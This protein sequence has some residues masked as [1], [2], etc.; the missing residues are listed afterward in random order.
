MTPASINKTGMRHY[1]KIGLINRQDMSESFTTQQMSDGHHTYYGG[2]MKTSFLH[3]PRFNHMLEGEFNKPWRHSNGSIHDIEQELRA[4]QHTISQSNESAS[5]R[6]DR[7]V[8]AGLTPSI[9]IS[10]TSPWNVGVEAVLHRIQ[11]EEM[12]EENQAGASFMMSPQ[13]QVEVVNHTRPKVLI[14]T[15]ARQSQLKQ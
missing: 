7:K 1:R 2:F 8:L 14:K 10:E 6:Q 4:S 3:S 15:K 13:I 5:T 12:S 11:S 9:Q